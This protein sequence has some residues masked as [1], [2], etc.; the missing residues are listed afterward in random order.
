MPLVNGNGL[1]RAFVEL[2]GGPPYNSTLQRQYRIPKMRNKYSR[3]ETSRPQSQFLHLCFC[4]R[5]KYSIQLEENS[6]I[7]GKNIYKSLTEN[8]LGLRPHSFFSGGT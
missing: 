2:K 6:W 5:F 7:D 3:N 8:K 4:E 1:V